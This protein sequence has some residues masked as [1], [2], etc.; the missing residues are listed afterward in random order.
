M[1][2]GEI[3]G[4]DRDDRADGAPVV[5]LFPWRCFPEYPLHS[6]VLVTATT[7]YTELLNLQLLKDLWETFVK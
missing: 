3:E 1:Y 5:L 7:F 4:A 2:R 6:E